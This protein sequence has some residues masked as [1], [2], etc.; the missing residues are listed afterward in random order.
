MDQFSR[1]FTREAKKRMQDNKLACLIED[2]RTALTEIDE[3][4]IELAGAYVSQA[5]DCLEEAC[6]GREAGQR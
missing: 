1:R 3:L 4:G 2:L 5:I 6:A